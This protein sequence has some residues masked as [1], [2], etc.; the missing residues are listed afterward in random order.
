MT[1]PNHPKRRP[2]GQTARRT[3]L[4][5]M[6][7]GLLVVLLLGALARFC[8]STYLQPFYLSPAVSYMPTGALMPIPLLPALGVCLLAG[9]V[10]MAVWSLSR[11]RWLAVLVLLLVGGG[12]I[13]HYRILL[14]WGAMALWE[15]LSVLFTENT[16]FP[17]YFILE[18]ALSPTLKQP[19]VQAFL[20]GL[21]ALYALPLGWAVTR[22]R[23]FWLT[24]A[25][26]LPWLMPAFLAEVA[27]DWP[28][29]MVVCACWAA[30]LLS[31]LSAR[32]NPSGG[33]RVILLA[34]PACM[35][36]IAGVYLIF[37]RD[38]YVQPVWAV[39]TRDEL[40]ALD[41]FSSGD[42]PGAAAPST[43]PSMEGG[44]GIS[45]SEG[46]VDL[47]AAG[48]RRYTGQ[49][50][51]LAESSYSGPVYL[52][53]SAYALYANNTWGILDAEV[54][55]SLGGIS[56]LLSYWAFAPSAE[57][58]EMTITRSATASTLL[59]F[60]YQ[61]VAQS[62]STQDAITYRDSTLLAFQQ[63]QQYTL[64]FLPLDEEPVPRNDLSFQVQTSPQY[65]AFVYEHYLDVPQ[66]TAD[67]LRQ[68]Y[69]DAQWELADSGIQPAGTAT[70]YYAGA[71]NIAARIAQLLA[72][73][74]QY[75]L[76]TPA[77]PEEEDF[78]T[79]F[80]ET[81]RRGYCVHYA[82]AAAL[83]LRLEGIPARY[84]SGYAATIPES[85]AAQILDSNAHAWVEIYLDGYGWYP[86]E[87]TPS[88]PVEENPEPEAT[89]SA[90]PAPSPSPSSRPQSSQAPGA[91][92]APAE[93]PEV[94]DTGL[95]LQWLLWLIPVLA[96][97]SL[98]F[99][100]YRLRRNKWD[101][102]WT[103]PDR[104]A[105]VLAAYGWFQQLERWGGKP[106]PRT[107]ELVGK[108]RFSQH[109]LTPQE[110]DEVLGDL[111]GE[112]VRVEK[113][114][115]AWKRPLLRAL[116]YPDWPGPGSPSSP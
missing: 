92:D 106:S 16:G 18:P 71:L 36:V 57:T 33:A 87:V 8:L 1:K 75:D 111:R 52:K 93:G 72:L 82:S 101:R 28:A 94:Q 46:E 41:W 115:P 73:N 50:V 74:T 99:L 88:A 113:A 69:R 32:A 43:P 47:S 85:G 14:A 31:G 35:A 49:T 110:R 53:G 25:L 76:N 59:Y 104:N 39:N 48:P 24:F 95:S 21:A 61:P 3:P 17:G 23:S 109:T 54:L 11:Y 105:A 38:G 100:L 91:T 5:V 34:L 89:P 56:S 19:A 22:L 13:Y 64:S 27:M 51:L 103:R 15:T 77:T 7:D 84:V 26:T 29:L 79:Y 45:D 107:L 42:G 70:G 6:A 108:A 80:L 97:L 44:S 20:A 37:P 9:A 55:D 96:V 60:P 102:L 10:S 98:P 40:L 112:V 66:D 2:S 30:M 114:L 58:R 116:F 78:V 67:F 62:I 81:S 12:L 90:T 86:V 65:R 68:W 63:L 4:V 83:L